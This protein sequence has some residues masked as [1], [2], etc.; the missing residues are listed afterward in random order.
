MNFTG[1]SNAAQTLQP[2][3]GPVPGCDPVTGDEG[4]GLAAYCQASEFPPVFFPTSDDDGR[5]D[6]VHDCGGGD[7]DGDRDDDGHDGDAHDH[8]DGDDDSGGGDYDRSPRNS[9]DN[10]WKN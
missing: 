1:F 7:H 9:W 4:K 6:G 3:C 2:R 8:D 10:H 5:D